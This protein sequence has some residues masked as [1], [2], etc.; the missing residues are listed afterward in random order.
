[1]NDRLW[2]TKA[3]VLAQNGWGKTSPNPMVGAILVKKDREIGRGWHKQAGQPHAEINAINST[4]TEIKGATLYVTLEPCSTTGRTAPCVDSIIR[5]GISRV[6]VASMDPNPLHAGKGIEILRNQGIEVDLGIESD[7]AEKLNEAFF[8]WI[9][10]KRP[11]VLLKLAMTLDGKIATAGGESKWISGLSSRR[12]VQRLRQWADAVLV[13]AETVRRDNPGLLVQTPKNWS[14]HP[15]RI[16]A[17]KSGN[18][19]ISPQVLT[20]GVVDTRIVGFN[21]AEDWHNL[22]LKLGEEKM[23]SLLI[24]GG[25]E[26]AGVLLRWGFIDKVAI[27]IAP[28]ILGGRNSRPAIAGLNPL[29]LTDN[30]EVKDLK[31]TRSGQDHLATG[32]LTDVYRVH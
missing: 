31:I 27:F 19:G 16:V 9:R 12:K 20:D 29:R 2:M 25:G 23:T 30:I 18:L 21:K 22:L 17:S 13:G 8:C 4:N 6:V 14:R 24:E 32:Y 7:R 10:F 26:I 5:C 28:K 11:F 15:L 3:L 1:M